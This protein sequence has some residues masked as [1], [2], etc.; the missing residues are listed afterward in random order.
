MRLDSL[1]IAGR[2]KINFE[3]CPDEMSSQNNKCPADTYDRCL[4][5]YYDYF[6]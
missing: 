3:K 5:P 6:L 1:Q 4:I 2:K